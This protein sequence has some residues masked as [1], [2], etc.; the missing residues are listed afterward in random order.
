MLPQAEDVKG[1]ICFRGLRQ[2]MVKVEICTCIQK[3]QN[4][5]QMINA[6]SEIFALIF[7]S[8]MLDK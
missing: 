5:V 3:Q 1:F 8:N 2:G 4:I 6:L 7:P